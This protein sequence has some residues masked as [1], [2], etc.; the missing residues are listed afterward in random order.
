MDVGDPPVTELD[1]VI[2][3]EPAAEPVV[4]V[5]AVDSGHPH[6]SADDNGGDALGRRGDGG[7]G[8]PRGGE[9]ETVDPQFEQRVDRERLFLGDEVTGAEQRPIAMLDRGRVD[10]VD[11]V[12]EE[13]VVEVRDEHTENLGAP[14]YERLR[15]TVGPVAE[16]TG[17]IEDGTPLRLADVARSPHDEGHERLGHTGARR[18]VVDRR[19]L[20]AS[21]CRGPRRV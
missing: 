17:G 12:V 13:R 7:R 6:R 11:G 20:H 15:R 14:P 16:V 18:Y 9:H 21:P 10:A 1:E 8:H 5:D 3:D 19:V 4:V 2:D